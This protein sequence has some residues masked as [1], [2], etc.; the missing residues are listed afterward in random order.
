VIVFLLVVLALLLGF[1]AGACFEAC[2]TG[3]SLDLRQRITELDVQKS[4][5]IALLTSATNPHPVP[6]QRQVPG[7]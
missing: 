6:A 4:N 1:V 2:R 5:V 3:G 7:A